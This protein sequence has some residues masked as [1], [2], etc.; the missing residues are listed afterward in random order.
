MQITLNGEPRT[1]A[2]EITVH[3]L[4][5]SLGLKADR[6]AIEL[7]GSIVKKTLWST[8]ELRDGSRIEI[9]QFVGGG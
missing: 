5:D 4:I 6:V 9:V 7:D 8:L 2:S 3:D 1:L